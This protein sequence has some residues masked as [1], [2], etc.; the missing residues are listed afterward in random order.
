MA[1]TATKVGL[2]AAMGCGIGLLVSGALLAEPGETA[3]EAPAVGGVPQ[4]E[5]SL[6]AAPDDLVPGGEVPHSRFAKL[7]RWGEPA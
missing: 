4:D 7:A 2:R 3:P 6:W 1:G 5:D